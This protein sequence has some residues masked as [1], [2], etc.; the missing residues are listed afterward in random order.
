MATYILTWNPKRWNWPGDSYAQEIAETRRGKRVP[1]RWSCGNTKCIVPGDRVFLLR[2]GT[3]RGLIGSGYA[4]S[5]VFA[6][7][8]WDADRQGDDAYYVQYQSDTLLPVEQRLPIET[9]KAAKLDVAWNNLVKSGCSVPDQHAPRL[10]ELWAAHLARINQ[11]GVRAA[12]FADEV[13]K[14]KYTEGATEEIL[15]NS[16]ER[17]AEARRKCI[18]H[19][20]ARC[21]ICDFDFG[22][23]YGEIGEGY[24][25]VHHLKN[26]ATIRVEYEVDPIKDLRPVCPNCHAMLHHT[27]KPSIKK[28]RALVEKRQSQQ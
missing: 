5:E 26:L 18:L 20:G 25:H 3:D 1:S 27:S 22:E 14:K 13:P 10:E 2:Q 21:V 6:E 17:N 19:Y 8:H 28:L 12:Y 11:N 23:A 15:V 9:L 4:S 16:F 7:P 24:I